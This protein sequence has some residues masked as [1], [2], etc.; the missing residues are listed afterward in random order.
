MQPRYVKPLICLLL[1]LA[2]VA[3]YAPVRDHK[4]LSY[5]DHE[6][7]AENIVVHRGLTLEGIHWA[8]TTTHANNWHPLTW[9]SHMLDCQFYGLNPRGH[10]LTNV[11]LHVANTILLFLLLAKISGALWPSALVAALFALHPLHVE[12]V[13][14]VAERKDVLSTFFF[15]TT[16]WA[17]VWYT[18]AP[19]L[20]R[21][22]SVF[23]SFALGLLAKPMLV[24]LPFVL[25]LLDYWPLGRLHPPT[26]ATT[27]RRKAVPAASSW[28]R[29]L[30]LRLVLEKV[31]LLA[32]T[33][34][35]SILT[36]VAQKTGMMALEKISF[37]Y[38]FTNALVAYVRYLG[39][40]FWPVNL[41]VFYPHPGNGL[42]LWQ[43]AGAGLFLTGVTYLIL[44]NGREHPY[45]PVGWFWFLG[46]L[47]PA[48]GLVQVGDQAMADRYTY[49][50]LIGI[51]IILA[52]GAKELTAKWRV[53]RIAVPLGV[54]VLLV[55]LIPLARVQVGYWRNSV[56]LFEHAAAVTENNYLAYNMLISG[57][58]KE[59]KF[60]RALD[61]F[62]KAIQ[63]RSSP[64]EAYF[65]IG[66][67]YGEQ[68]MFDKAEGAIRKAIQY[69]ANDGRF[70]YALGGVLAGKGKID[71]AIAMY[72][73]A[74]QFKPHFA[75]AYNNLG[76]NYGRQ[77]RI[78]E[79]IA[80]LKKAIELA[81]GLAK[82]YCNLA[83]AY[84]Q[85]GN[86]E[87]VMKTLQRASK[88]DPENADVKR[89]LNLVKENDGN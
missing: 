27:G 49:I 40:T 42:H 85:Q 18:A 30:A 73:K 61:M 50:P 17:Y 1:I 2:T 5:D 12:S 62:G 64:A 71:E 10:H 60:D 79:A 24:T 25:L 83:I 77:G 65:R 33:A 52:W 72:E 14:W 19:S 11:V 43:A 84:G 37:F 22:L 16:L 87:A 39:K 45:L 21:Y 57:Y 46:T 26:K 59:K 75:D 34:I 58:A 88:I 56:M 89:M 38:R 8:F 74:I 69:K 81:P 80:A 54:A 35:S 23:L 4:F 68:N 47:V 78:D 76:V 32:L 86:I 28:D 6:Y 7:V 31:P 41:A 9:L 70:Y 66:L 48:I 63:A 44:K 51:F 3:V 67:V 29:R 36:L 20:P 15:L 55:L 53:E 82:A 13:A